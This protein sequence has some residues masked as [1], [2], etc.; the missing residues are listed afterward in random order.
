[1]RARVLMVVAIV[2]TSIAAV[3]TANADDGEPVQG[4]GVDG[5]VID[6]SFS[7]G[8]QVAGMQTVVQPDGKILVVGTISVPEAGQPS[9]PGDQHGFIIRY[10][11]SGVRDPDFGTGGMTYFP[12]STVS[13]PEAVAV[14]A[15]GNIMVGGLFKQQNLWRLTP[16]GIIDPTFT[17][18]A[19]SSRTWC[20]SPTAACW[21]STRQLA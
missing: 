7:D 17:W 3:P 8:H 2:C 5:V 13:Q 10:L 14:L 19:S 6:D 4:F 18:S 15:N 11:A 20:P 21:S 1:M 16:A 9:G 12:Q